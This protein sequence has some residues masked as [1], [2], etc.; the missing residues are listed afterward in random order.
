MRVT[1]FLCAWIVASLSAT[2]WAQYG[3]YAAPELTYLPPAS[4][5]GPAAMAYP[6]APAGYGW[7]AQTGAVVPTGMVTQGAPVPSTMTAPDYPAPGAKTLGRPWGAESSPLGARPPL[8]VSPAGP[9]PYYGPVAQAPVPQPTPAGPL[10]QAPVAASNYGP[11]PASYGP[12]PTN[13]GSAPADYGC[14]CGFGPAMEAACG[15][16]GYDPW[17]AT[18]TGLYMVRNNANRVWL[19]LDEADETRNLMHTG[20]ELEWRP[21]GEVQ[22]GRRFGCGM[23]TVAGSYWTL[24]PF[25]G[26]WSPSGASAYSTPLCDRAGATGA[27][28]VTI[29]GQRARSFFDNTVTPHQ[30]T[31][32]SEVHNVEINVTRHLFG[33]GMWE[34]NVSAGP[35]YFRFRDD[36]LFESW[37]LIDRGSGNEAAYAYLYDKVTNNL[38]GAQIGFETAFVAHPRLRVYC[39]P[40]VGI[41]GNHMEGD[42]QMAGRIGSDPMATAIVNN[43][44][45]PNYPLHVTRDSFAVLSQVDVG[46]DWMLGCHWTVRV[47]Y[48]LL[49]ASNVAL[50]DH[51]IPFCVSDTNEMSYL[52]DNGD[53]L[54]HGGYAGLTY[55][56]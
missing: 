12:A 24:D 46:V 56:F 29:D 3:L 32:S 36:L 37:N 39:A 45:N 18:V 25:S 43:G 1:V 28:Y 41:Y 20:N 53:L 19:S 16:C 21:G 23:W 2:A 15:G 31:Q 6:A 30:L 42:F 40:K 27:N 55:S 54:L 10:G 14:G 5:Y 52:K 50:A 51:Q 8:P 7:P 9:Q 34:F 4:A 33:N 48:R 11:A 35:R 22:I 49:V 17:F 38:V 44:S 13:Y 47:G 26:T